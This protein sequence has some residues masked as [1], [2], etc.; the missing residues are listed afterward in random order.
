MLFRSVSQSRYRHYTQ[1]PIAAYN[2]WS[3][4]ASMYSDII[5]RSLDVDLVAPKQ[6]TN[7]IVN[8][9]AYTDA[10]GDGL[11]DGWSAA[12]GTPSIINRANTYLGKY[13]QLVATSTSAAMITSPDVTLSAGST[14]LLSAD[15]VYTPSSSCTAQGWP[16]FSGKTVNSAY[17]NHVIS[18]SYSGK[19]IG[20]I[21]PSVTTYAACLKAVVTGETGA[22]VKMGSVVIMNVTALE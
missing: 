8:G 14:Y 18:Q 13:Q 22:T 2:A 4:L 9:T 6:G 10:S 19:L 3:D 15:V 21:T 16:S 7:L 12:T 5:P 17:I 1:Y 11:A 20:F